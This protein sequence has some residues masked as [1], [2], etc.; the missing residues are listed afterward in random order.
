MSE[1]VNLLQTFKFKV[2]LTPSTPRSGSTALGDGSFAECSGLQLE[3]DIRELLEGG[4]NDGVVRRVGRVKL[5]PIVLKRG[6]FSPEP[7]QPANTELWEWLTSMV[8]GGPIRRFNGEIAL[9]NPAFTYTHATWIFERGL[10]MKVVG[11]T[12]IAKTGD[13]AIE[14]LYILHESLRLKAGG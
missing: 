11:P 2:T 12:L 7:G 5:V 3:A 13:I 9:T 1:T 14:E 6:M 10:P 4:R 8:G